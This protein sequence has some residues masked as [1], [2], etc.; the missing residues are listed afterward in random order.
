MKRPLTSKAKV[1]R[2]SSVLLPSVVSWHERINH[3][4][5]NQQI[6]KI[7]VIISTANIEML[8]CLFL[9][10][11]LTYGILKGSMSSQLNRTLLTSA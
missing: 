7:L 5:K 6:P 2:I 4:P 11:C 8:G 10:P 9:I 3:T 1:S